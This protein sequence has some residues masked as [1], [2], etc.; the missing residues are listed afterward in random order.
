MRILTLSQRLEEVREKIAFFSEKAGRDPGDVMILGATKG[1][2][3]KL[4][5]E[6]ASLGL[7][8]FGENTVQE[9]QKKIPL[10]SAEVEWRMIGHLQRNKVKKALELFKMIETVDRL[11]L[12]LEIEKRALGQIPCLIE[13]NTSGEESKFGVKPE[14][15]RSLFEEMLKLTKIKVL[16]LMTLGPYPPEEKRSRRAFSLLRELKE[17]MEKEFSIQLP[18]LSMGMSEDYHWAILEG[19]TEIRLGRAIFG[20]RR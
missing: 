12:A 17:K 15:L 16:G 10:V 11:P 5:D 20:E 3:P 6:A 7:K 18:V 4:I 9:A 2:S 13:V 19:T 14:E 8:V 1:V